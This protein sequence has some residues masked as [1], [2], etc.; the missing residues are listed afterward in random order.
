[1]V[2]TGDTAILYLLLSHTITM[3]R[4]KRLPGVT[5]ERIHK[6]KNALIHRMAPVPS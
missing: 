4:L 1:M 3:K 2:S 6:A 5:L